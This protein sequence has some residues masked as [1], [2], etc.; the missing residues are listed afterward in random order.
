M[1]SVNVYII[2]LY[3]LSKLFQIILLILLKFYSKLNCNLAL[4]SHC[5]SYVIVGSS[6]LNFYLGFKKDKI[7]SFS[8]LHHSLQ[9]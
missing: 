2:I 8:T 4:F 5:R 1:Q 6:I 3:F 9:S 7:T